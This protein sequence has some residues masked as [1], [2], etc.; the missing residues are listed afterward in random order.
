MNSLALFDWQPSGKTVDSDL[1]AARLRTQL[2]RVITYMAFGHWRTLHEIAIAVAPATEPS[3]SARLRDMRK[4]GWIVDRRRRG[5]PK[6][7]LHEYR[8][9]RAKVAA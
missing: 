4:L 7:G 2:G 8:C 3:V 5:D 1:D 6:K 9:E